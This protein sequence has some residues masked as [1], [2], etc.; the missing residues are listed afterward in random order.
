[1]CSVLKIRRLHHIGAI[2]GVTAILDWKCL[3][4]ILFR[5][6]VYD[7]TRCLFDAVPGVILILL[8]DKRS[9]AGFPV[10]ADYIIDKGT[11]MGLRIGCLVK[12]CCRWKDAN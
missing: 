12:E 7:W 1:M 2:C 9:L 10:D 5:S 11:G 8:L 4:I 6:V 3:I